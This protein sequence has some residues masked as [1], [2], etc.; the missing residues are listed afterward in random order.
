MLLVKPEQIQRQC[1]NFDN[2]SQ[3]DSSYVYNNIFIPESY[4]R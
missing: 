2:T 3:V 4:N 1:C